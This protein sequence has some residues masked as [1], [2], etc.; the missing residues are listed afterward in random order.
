MMLSVLVSQAGKVILSSER[1]KKKN[2]KPEVSTPLYL[3]DS[4]IGPPYKA[5]VTRRQ[6]AE[7]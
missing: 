7:L 4:T 1:G 6:L 2:A 5:Y 3:R